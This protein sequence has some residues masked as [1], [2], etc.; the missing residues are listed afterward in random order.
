ME[1]VPLSLGQV[2]PQY[3]DYNEIRQQVRPPG[4]LHIWYRFRVGLGV[5]LSSNLSLEG[6]SAG[7]LG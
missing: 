7:V 2:T 5:L 3:K 6:P 1:L 4:T